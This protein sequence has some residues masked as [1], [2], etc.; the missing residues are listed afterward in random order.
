TSSMSFFEPD[1]PTARRKLRRRRK[2]NNRLASV[3][4]SCI[5]TT[6][7]MNWLC[8]FG[9]QWMGCSCA[10]CGKARDQEHEWVVVE[11]RRKCRRCGV[12]GG[13]SHDWNGCLCRLCGAENHHWVQGIC[14]RCSERCSHPHLE[15]LWESQL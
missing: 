12:V 8:L 13:I 6:S 11:C 5:L 3:S 14:S 10:R 4:K 9:H 15:P 7:D 2:L 1:R